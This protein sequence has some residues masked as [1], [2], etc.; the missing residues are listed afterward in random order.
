MDK[1]LRDGVPYLSRVEEANLRRTEAI[2]RDKAQ[3]ELLIDSED[4]EACN[5]LEHVRAKIKDWKCLAHVSFPMSS[6]QQ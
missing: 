6:R 4:L 2:S 5:F 1:L 3:A